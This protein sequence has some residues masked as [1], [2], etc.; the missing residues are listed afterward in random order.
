MERRNCWEAKACGRQPGGDNVNTLGACPATLP[1]EYDGVNRG[2]RGGRFCWAVAG[3]F[4]GGKVQGTFAQKLLDCLSCG[5]LK[6]V[7]EEE[8][9]A[10]KLTP[11]DTE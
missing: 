8:N 1:S 5:F 11:S 9:G 10:F 2:R 3:T 4:C 6:E 7:E